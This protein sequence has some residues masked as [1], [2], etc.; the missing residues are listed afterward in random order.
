MIMKNGAKRI[1]HSKKGQ[2]AAEY[3]VTAAGIF[4]AIVGFYIAYSHIVP[5]QFETGAKFI[6]SVYDVN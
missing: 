4:L 2:S 5:Q 1:L 6:I 3:I